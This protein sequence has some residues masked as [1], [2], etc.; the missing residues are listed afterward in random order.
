MRELELVGF[1]LYNYFNIKETEFISIN[2]LTTLVGKDEERKREFISLLKSANDFSKPNVKILFLLEKE[3]KNP[4]LILEFKMSEKLMNEIY[5]LSNVDSIKNKDKIKVCVT[6]KGLFNI[7]LFEENIDFEAEGIKTKEIINL[8]KKNIPKFEIID[9]YT[10]DIILDSN[11]DQKKVIV[12]NNLEKYCTEKKLSL[13]Q[14]YKENFGENILIHTTTPPYIIHD[15][16]IENSIID[17]DKRFVKVGT[18]VKDSEFDKTGMLMVIGIFLSYLVMIVRFL[19]ILSNHRDDKIGLFDKVIKSLCGLGIEMLIVVIV[20]FIIAIILSSFEKSKYKGYGILLT[21]PLMSLI[22]VTYVLFPL[23]VLIINFGA[24]VIISIYLTFSSYEIVSKLLL[25]LVNI[26]LSILPNIIPN[27]NINSTEIMSRSDFLPYMATIVFVSAM[28]YMTKIARIII[29]FVFG[30]ANKPLVDYSQ[31]FVDKCCNEKTVRLLLYLFAFFSY[32]INILIKFETREFELV[33]EGFLTWIILD[34][35]LFNIS[36][37]ID[38]MKAKKKKIER[39]KFQKK[40]SKYFDDSII[41]K[42]KFQLC[43]IFQ[44]IQ[45]YIDDDLYYKIG[46]FRIKK[47]NHIIE[48]YSDVFILYDWIK[49]QSILE[50]EK[51]RSTLEDLKRKID[52]KEIELLSS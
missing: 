19:F 35:L 15:I 14:Y 12:F 16:K 37:Y 34:V 47:K 21:S 8:L 1:K 28:P 26:I 45:E 38:Y 52:F 49:K 2:K 51:Y 23:I 18:K 5:G 50:Y 10:Q 31:N 22:T 33:K 41:E 4:K 39:L 42:N 25:N 29:K 44:K 17:M 11:K 13:E 30:L 6:E 9:S 24:T 3:F 7:E 43:D 40:I 32:F 48:Y 36:E 46:G 27:A 20:L